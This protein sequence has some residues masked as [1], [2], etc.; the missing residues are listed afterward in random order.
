MQSNHKR[1]A[2]VFFV[3][4]IEHVVTQWNHHEPL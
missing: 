2:K 4:N 3:S 1:Y